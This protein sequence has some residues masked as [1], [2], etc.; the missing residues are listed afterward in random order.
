MENMESVLARLLV[1][2][3]NVIQQATEELKV[4]LREPGAVEQLCAVLGRSSSAQV[5]QYAAVILRKRLGKAR[6]WTKLD[7]QFRDSLKQEI[8]RVLAGEQERFIRSAIAQLVGAVARHELPGNQWPALLE[9]LSQTMLA[10]NLPDKELG[11]YTLAIISQSCSEQLKPHLTSLLTMFTALLT[12]PS[13]AI[14]FQVIQAMTNMAPVLGSDQLTGYQSL[15]PAVLTSISGLARTDEDQAAE[16]LDLVDALVDQEVAVLVPHVPAVVELCLRLA[17]DTEMG[18]PLRCKALHCIDWLTRLKKKVITKHKLV[19]PILSVVV[20]ILSTHV[21]EEEEEEDELSEESNSVVTASTRLIDSLAIN[22][23]P[24]KLLT[25]LLV[26]VQRLLVSE[27]EYERKAAFLALAMT[28]EGC[29]E[30]VR[31]KHLASWLQHVCQGITHPSTVVRNAALFT[32]GQFAEHL[33]T[34]L[35]LLLLVGLAAVSGQ[36]QRYRYSSSR[37]NTRRPSQHEATPADYA[38][39]AAKLEANRWIR[40]ASF[41]I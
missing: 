26:H 12:T 20:P 16:A 4:L 10:E 23:P 15:L 13:A 33:Q 6:Q 24:E 32:L 8:L 22:L 3:N 7:Q 36:P 40:I 28:A 30:R 25:P 31:T 19:E 2:D 18:E 9:F 39:L 1:A 29:S 21:D 34:L 11:V 37:G 14:H 5:R 35:F 17:A 41:H 27:D 38:A